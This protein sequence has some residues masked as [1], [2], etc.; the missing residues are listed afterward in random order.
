MYTCPTFDISQLAYNVLGDNFFQISSAGM[1][2]KKTGKRTGKGNK[3]TKD[4][5]QEM[6]AEAADEIAGLS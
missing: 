3:G 6:I 2:G 1:T 5:R 4:A